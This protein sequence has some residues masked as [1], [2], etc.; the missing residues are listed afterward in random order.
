MTFISKDSRAI[1][2]LFSGSNIRNEIDET[3]G[4]VWVAEDITAQKSMTEELRIN[5]ERLKTATSILR[6]DIINDLSVIKSAVDIYRNEQDETMFDEIENRVKKSIDTINNQRDQVKFLDSHASLDEYDLGEVL[7]EVVKSYPNIE[8]HI[9]GAGK[10]YADRAIYSVFENIVNNAVR[11]GK[12]TKLDIEIIS[13]KEHYEIRF[14]DYGIGIPDEIKDK[15]FDEGFHYGETG[16]TGIGLYI[17]KRTIEEYGGEV[18][19]KDNNPEGAIFI[20]KL[21]KIIET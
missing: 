17:V 14:K 21:K 3:L 19:V 13:N 4:I 10:A 12:T 18:S 1:N 16:H 20:V 9:T 11:H 7:G 15:V 6:H 8:I 2:L 5:R